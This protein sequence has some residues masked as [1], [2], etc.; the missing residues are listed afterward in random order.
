MISR[1]EKARPVP[2]QSLI[3]PDLQPGVLPGSAGKMDV[4]PPV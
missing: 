2:E 3:A 4:Q 1:I